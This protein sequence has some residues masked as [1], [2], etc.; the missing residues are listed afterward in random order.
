MKKIILKSLLYTLALSFMVVISC[1]NE[2]EK[3][4]YEKTDY[5]QV[6]EVKYLDGSID[7]LTIN[8]GYELEIKVKKRIPC[9]YCY[10]HSSIYSTNVKSVSIIEYRLKL[11]Q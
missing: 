2:P 8:H 10:Q 9:L 1:N 3:I 5:Y 7:T 6:V 11:P 4:K